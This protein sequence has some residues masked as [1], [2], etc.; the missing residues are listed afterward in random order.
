MGVIKTALEI[1]L[2]KTGSVKSDKSCIDQF[3][4]KQKGKKIAGAFMAGETDLNREIKEIPDAQKDSF[5]Q[6]VFDVLISQISLPAV[7]SDNKEDEKRVETAG[8][9]LSIVVNNKQFGRFFQELTQVFSR[10]TQETAHYDQAIK[11]QYAPKL[12]QK[13][14]ELTRRFGREVHIDPF[15]DPEFVS[16]YNQHM[17]AL[18]SNY[19]NAVTQVK[20]EIRRIFIESLAA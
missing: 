13:E 4:A 9:G 20:E 10:F 15:Q 7:N 11:Q 16:F 18:K 14:E 12:R 19:E 1:A 8:K 6:G 17:T 2:E 5:K 3:D